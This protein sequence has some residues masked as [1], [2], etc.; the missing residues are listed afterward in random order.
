[1]FLANL[2]RMLSIDDLTW[3]SARIGGSAGSITRG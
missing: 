1:M 2:M 3:R